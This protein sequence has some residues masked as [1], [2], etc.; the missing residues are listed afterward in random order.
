MSEPPTSAAR[1]PLAGFRVIDFTQMLL[2]PHATRQL[3]DLGADVIKIEPRAGDPRRTLGPARH[4]NMSSQF[5]QTN[6]GK[7]SIVLDAKTAAGREVV[8]RLAET[9]DVFVHNSRPQ[10]M[11]RLGL[12]YEDVEKRNP[13]IVY[14]AGVGFDERGRYAGKPAYDDMI[15]GLAAIPALQARLSGAPGYVPFNLSDSLCGL[16]LA[17]AILAGL[18]SRERTGQGQAIELP[19]FETMADFVLTEHL[20]GHTFSPPA[21][22]M[23]ATRLFERRPSPTKDGHICFWIGTDDQ[24]ERFLRAIGRS[25]L[26]GDE[27]FAK[28]GARNRN[29][30]EF[31]R[32]IDGA[33]L[34]RAT[35]EW[36]SIFAAAD[37]PAMPLHTLETLIEDPHLA[38]V[39]LL[40][41]TEH[42]SEGSIVTPAVPSRWSRTSPGTPRP[43]P[44]LG[45]HTRDILLEAGYSEAEIADM[46]A[47]GAAA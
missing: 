12:A 38:D 40:A 10:A 14:C 28:R 18:L 42:P 27:R 24:C 2:G 6:R 23:G 44:R 21:G 37:V 31:F 17:Q 5:L 45:E 46:L 47:S 19:M 29:I 25:D 33:L 8:L 13:R 20:W 41:T 36:V 26:A 3:A 34:A 35:A 32:L 16:M 9:A 11:H 43:A 4:P 30:A 7:R 15:Q 1:G 22:G 39:G